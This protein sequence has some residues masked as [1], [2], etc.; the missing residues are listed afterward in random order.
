MAKQGLRMHA[1]FWLYLADYLQGSIPRDILLFGVL[2]PWQ[3]RVTCLHIA[4]SYAVPSLRTKA[5]SH[6][7]VVHFI[8][9]SPHHHLELWSAYL[10]FSLHSK[11][12]L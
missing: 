12:I 10:G 1:G 11:S 7:H 4:Q 8:I 9:T 5:P 2:L 6:L 3:M